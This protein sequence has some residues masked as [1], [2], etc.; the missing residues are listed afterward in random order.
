MALARNSVLSLMPTVAGV[1]VGILT[2]PLY[3]SIVGNERYG[4]LLMAFVLLGYFGQADF[5]LGR[6]ITQR[7]SSMSD[8]APVERAS[9]VWSALA[10]ASVIS[11][12]GG[13]GLYFA[14][15]LVFRNFFDAG[16]YIKAEVITAA[17]LFTL[18]V[19]VVMFTGVSTG[20]L[21]GLERFGLVSVGN[22]LST[23]L[24][25]VL[26]LVSA[27]YYSSDFSW[28]LAASIVGRIIGL[29]PIL[30][31]MASVFLYKQP[32]NPSVAQSRRLFSFGSWI[33][34]SAIIG[35]MMTMADRLVIGGVLGAAAVVAYSVPV[36]IASRTI[37]LPMAIVQAIFP[38]MASHAEGISVEL[39][40][41]SV[42]LVGQIY[43]FLIVGMICFS[44]PLLAIWLGND[45]DPRSALVGQ[46]TLIGM[47]INAIANV[48]YALIQA[49]GNSRYTAIIHLIELPI[50][51]FILYGLGAAF[52]LS[53]VALAF[54]LRVALDCWLLFRKAGF[55]VGSLLNRLAGP[56]VIIL[57]AF[58]SSLWIEDWL[59]GLA[60]TIF[61]CTILTI[62]TWVQMP[63]EAKDWIMVRLRRSL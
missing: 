16:P 24:S 47:W 12:I 54:T 45:L 56:S 14:V 50:Y 27:L 58:V 23:V 60:T 11:L 61:L 2:V 30:F 48:P 55:V 40:K 28:L 34:V 8:S 43:A 5:G 46:I 26:P 38:R 25:Q 59:T 42:V 19:P 36:Q 31:S 20:A 33:M 35:P 49:R 62:L 53:G 21:V 17:W 37:M 57:L 7:L 39:G 9:V 22:T 44:K 15:D 63:T 1:G 52:G 10:G 18:C 51:F 41:E 29:A 3:V 6:A 4:A 13:A 32:I